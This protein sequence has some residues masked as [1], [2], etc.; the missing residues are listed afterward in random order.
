MLE[1]SWVELARTTPLKD[2]CQEPKAKMPH[3]DRKAKPMPQESLLLM[4]L[5]V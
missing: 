2:N 1:A 5:A 4:N 3:Q